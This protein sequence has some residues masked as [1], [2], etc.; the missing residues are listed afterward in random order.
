MLLY[1]LIKNVTKYLILVVRSILF[2]INKLSDSLVYTV[3]PQSYGPNF[4]KKGKGY[5]TF[6]QYH[7]ALASVLANLCSVEIFF[8]KIVENNIVSWGKC[9][10]SELRTF[11]TYEHPRFPRG[12]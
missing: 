11:Q 12:S 5:S 1:P 8:M 7:K 9:M 3:E 4:Y 10:I 2:R 6:S